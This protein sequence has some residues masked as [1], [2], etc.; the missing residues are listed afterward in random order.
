MAAADNHR[1]AS[2]LA[3]KSIGGW[4]ALVH[5]LGTKTVMYCVPISVFIGYK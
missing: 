5:C 2:H 3:D 1:L 4:R